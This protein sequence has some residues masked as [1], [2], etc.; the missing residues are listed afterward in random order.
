MRGIANIIRGKVIRPNN[1]ILLGEFSM[2]SIKLERSCFKKDLTIV[3]ISHFPSTVIKARLRMMASH[4][5]MEIE[6]DEQQ[7]PEC[8]PNTDRMDQQVHKLIQFK[9]FYVQM[10]FVVG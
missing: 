3:T 1:D 10:A 5:E 9:V 6:K 8:E 4:S 7:A 2:R